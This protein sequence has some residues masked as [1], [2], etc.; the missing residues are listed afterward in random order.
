MCTDVPFQVTSFA[1]ELAVHYPNPVVR[2]FSYQPSRKLATPTCEDRNAAVL[3]CTPLLDQIRDAASFLRCIQ[4]ELEH[5]SLAILCTRDRERTL[6]SSGPS[7]GTE[8][9]PFEL[10]SW[11]SR[12]GIPVLFMGHTT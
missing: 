9:T 2:V 4:Q 5:N 10:R 11:L 12:R 7:K 1:H 3:L 8:W 6:R